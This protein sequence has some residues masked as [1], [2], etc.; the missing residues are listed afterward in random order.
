VTLDVDGAKRTSDDGSPH[1]ADLTTLARGGVL[2]LAGVV[3]TAAAGFAIVVVVTRGLTPTDAGIF[4]ESIALF[5]ILG[6]IAQWGA[7]I[8]VVRAI[9][10][11]RVRGRERDIART[12]WAAYLPV[13]VIGSILGFLML[14]Y[15]G[16]LG[17]VLTNGAHGSDLSPALRALA[18]FLPI[19][20][21]FMVGLGATRGFGTML[22]S[23]VIDRFG[24]ALAQLVLV[25]ALV[26][27]GGS[28]ALYG[29]AWAFPFGFG[30]VAV[31]VWLSRRVA[32]TVHATA[33]GAREPRPFSAL[34]REFWRFTAPRGLASVFAVMVLW[35]STLLLGALRTPAEAGAYAAAARFLVFGQFIIAAITQVVAPQLSELLTRGEHER[36]RGVYATATWWLMAVSWPLYVTLIVLGPSL[37]SVFGRGYG[38]SANALVILGSAML[39]ATAIGPV[40]MVLLMAGRSVWNLVNTIITV[41]AN[42]GLNLWLIPHLGLTGAAIAWAVSILLNNLLPLIEVWSFVRLQPFGKGSIV[43]G[44]SALVWFGG[45]GLVCRNVMGDGLLTV[46]V[47]GMIATVGHAATLWRSRDVLHLEVLRP[48]LRRT[49]GPSRLG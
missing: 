39:V 17:R 31:S 34:L 7:D 16:F 14:V 6:A 3:V 32:A 19:Y 42:I 48:A 27:A 13:I 41:I 24:R 26:V 8:G 44:V 38:Q 23:T 33:E 47:A 5:S 2:N 4:F 11:Y 20:G 29:L 40:D 21:V 12:I 30:C 22:P 43:S 37:L 46:L 1:G 35:L 10:R 36:A 25:A 28:I 9:P 15:S 45:V 49:A 18:P